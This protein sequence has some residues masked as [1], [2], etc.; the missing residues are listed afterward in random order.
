MP[1]AS[2]FP[3]RWVTREA[4]PFEDNEAISPEAFRQ[5]RA[6]G[7]FAVHW[8]AHGHGYGLPRAIDDDIRAG[9]SVVANV[10][11]GVVDAMRRGY[12]EVTVVSITAPPEVLAERLAARARSSDGQLADRLGRAVDGAAAAPDVTIVNLGSVEHH[13]RELVRI[14]KGM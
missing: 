13:A 6:H 5:A 9:R 7:D 4:S 14:I 10:S 11:R 12:A 8:E 2:C 1:T 3:R